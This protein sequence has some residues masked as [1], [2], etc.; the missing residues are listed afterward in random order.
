MT[1]P[2]PAETPVQSVAAE[3]AGIIDENGNLPSWDVFHPQEADI[4]AAA[5]PAALAVP[6]PQ[7]QQRRSGARWGALGL[8]MGLAG[9]LVGLV[10]Q[11]AFS[12]GVGLVVAI[13]VA[14]VAMALIGFGYF[15]F[16]S[17]GRN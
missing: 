7:D 10:A 5:T 17:S 3:P 2:E 16:W 13:G 11:I 12:G 1:I 15:R 4:A 14:I 9:V 6:D 8:V